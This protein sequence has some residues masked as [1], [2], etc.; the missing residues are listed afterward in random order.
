MWFCDKKIKVNLELINLYVFQRI[1]QICNNSISHM[2]FL[3]FDTIPAI[4]TLSNWYQRP[5][6]SSRNKF[7][8]REVFDLYPNIQMV[9][10]LMWPLKRY[11]SKGSLESIWSIC[12]TFLMMFCFILEMWWWVFTEDWWKI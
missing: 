12:L 5:W 7:Q 9:R 1:L 11:K 4:R 3:P 6:V 2:F 10:L 8:S